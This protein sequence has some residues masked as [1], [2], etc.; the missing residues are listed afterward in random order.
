MSDLDLSQIKEG[1][2]LRPGDHLVVTVENQVA[3]QV[4]EFSEGLR[5]RLGPDIKV[6]V[7][8]GVEMIA[9]IEGDTS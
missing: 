4:Y 8:A 1:L 3:K 6:T 7:I 5:E 2:V 9:K